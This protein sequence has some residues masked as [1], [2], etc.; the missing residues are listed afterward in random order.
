MNNTQIISCNC[1]SAASCGA[2]L[3][4]KHPEFKVSHIY[5]Y[6]QSCKEYNEPMCWYCGSPITNEQP[7]GRSACCPDC[8]KD[9]R[10]CRNCR[11]Y[12]PGSGG[13]CRE[14]SAEAQPDRERA[15]FCDWF[16]LDEKYR[17]QSGRQQGDM[18]KAKVSR[19]AFDDL[20][21]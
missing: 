16:F 2:R 12:L 19:A 7:I 13:G 5:L 18:E 15:N 20:F 3:V 6:S 8:R 17:R 21:K 10:S 1:G 9:L 14:S 4:R 11:F